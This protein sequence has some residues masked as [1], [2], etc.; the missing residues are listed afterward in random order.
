VVI[1]GGII[2]DVWL[3]SIGGVAGVSGGGGGVNNDIGCKEQLSDTVIF[4]TVIPGSSPSK[5]T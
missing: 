4:V 5:N 3:G 1:I 2:G